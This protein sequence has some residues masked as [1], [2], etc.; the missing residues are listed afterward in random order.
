MNDTINHDLADNTDYEEFYE[1]GKMARDVLAEGKN[2]PHDEL[3]ERYRR[4]LLFYGNV[5]IYDL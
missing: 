2:T 4:D 5:S 3:G 1:R